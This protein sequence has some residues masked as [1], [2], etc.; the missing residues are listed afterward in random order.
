[1]SCV[2]QEREIIVSVV[3]REGELVGHDATTNTQKAL[4][5]D[6]TL[7][8]RK[9]GVEDL[10]NIPGLHG[11]EVTHQPGTSP[12]ILVPMEQYQAISGLDVVL[13]K[14]LSETLCDV[15]FLVT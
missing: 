3:P 10:A 11:S 1:M 7:M 2:D 13:L 14:E 6:I 9:I 5:H 12:E 15:I 4:G 8:N